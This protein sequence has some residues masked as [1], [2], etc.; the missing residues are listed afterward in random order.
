M[1]LDRDTKH[2]G[3]GR[4]ATNRLT[5]IETLLIICILGLLLMGGIVRYW[6]ARHDSLQRAEESKIHSQLPPPS[7]NASG[8]R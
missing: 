7:E 8:K 4:E 6:L 2:S 3:L 5:G 1:V